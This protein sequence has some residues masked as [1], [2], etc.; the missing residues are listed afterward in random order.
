MEAIKHSEYEASS[1]ARLE[2]M[3]EEAIDED[4]ID[5]LEGDDDVEDDIDGEGIGE[6]DEELEALIAKIPPSDKMDEDNLKEFAN[7]TES[8]LVSGGL[9]VSEGATLDTYKIWL[10]EKPKF[11]AEKVKAAN[12]L[13]NIREYKR[14]KSLYEEAKKAFSQIKSNISSIKDTI[15][16]NIASYGVSTYKFFGKLGGFL[17][18]I[19]PV[20]A[21]IKWILPGMIDELF[22]QNWEDDRVSLQT[23]DIRNNDE[24]NIVDDVM[25][26]KIKTWNSVKNN[27]IRQCEIFIKYCELR[28]KECNNPEKYPDN[29]DYTD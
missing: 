20:I 23:I 28:I 6:D 16:S 29:S 21:G 9:P 3:L 26:K 22:S 17:L 4:I 15:G 24:A 10:S 12:K 19:T 18:S 11:A 13:Y 27:I 1:D 8:F 7:L 25:S 5:A 2:A 14:A